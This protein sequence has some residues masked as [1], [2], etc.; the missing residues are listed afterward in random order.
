MDARVT[1]VGASSNPE[2]YSYQ[3]VKLL[4]ARN[5]SIRAYW[6]P[7]GVDA[8]PSTGTLMACLTGKGYAQCFAPDSGASSQLASRCCD[9]ASRSSWRAWPCGASSHCSSSRSL[10][11]HLARAGGR[12]LS[13]SHPPRNPSGPECTPL[14][15]GLWPRLCRAARS[16]ELERLAIGMMV[17]LGD[18]NAW[19]CAQQVSVPSACGSMACAHSPLLRALGMG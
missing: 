8:P 1:V 6:R 4:V 14:T 3:S 9:L 7:P 17:L 19:C 2:R 5:K 15:H 16:P 12:P 18:H 10:R 13:P 11:A